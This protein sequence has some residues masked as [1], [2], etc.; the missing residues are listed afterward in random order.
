MNPI[1]LICFILLVF[2]VKLLIAIKE[3]D[4]RINKEEQKAIEEEKKRNDHKQYA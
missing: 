1:I 3:I 4:V 2:F